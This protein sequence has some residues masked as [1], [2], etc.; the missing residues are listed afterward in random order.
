MTE[1]IPTVHEVKLSTSAPAAQAEAL[2]SRIAG[3][4]KASGYSERELRLKT[5]SELVHPDDLP[6]ED[7]QFEA[8]LSGSK[9]G[10]AADQRFIRKD[11]RILYVR[12]SAQCMWKNDKTLDCILILVQD[13]TARQALG[14]GN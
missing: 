4:L 1:T 7:A 6:G 5:W 9:R 10:Y 13:V 11:G 2:A 3:V 12:L 14:A 8:M